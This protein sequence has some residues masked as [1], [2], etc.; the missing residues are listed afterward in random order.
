MAYFERMSGAKV[1][2]CIMGDK[3]TFVIEDGYMGRAIGK[4]GVN[5][6]KLESKLKKRVKL[7][8][9]SSDVRQFVRNLV[10]PIDVNDVREENSIVTISAKDTTSRAMIIGREKS[11][12]MQIKDILS[13]YFN[14]KDLKV[15]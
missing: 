11:N 13:R 9:Y 1:K 12:L 10:H 2:D 8:E 5:I 15:A 14:L 3:V 7:V 4:N 6:K